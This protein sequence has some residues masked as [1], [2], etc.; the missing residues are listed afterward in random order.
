MKFYLY[1]N[2]VKDYLTVFK[3]IFNILDL[4]FIPYLGPLVMII[5][6]DD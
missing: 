2:R 1:L 4:Y 6:Y 3:L 5:V